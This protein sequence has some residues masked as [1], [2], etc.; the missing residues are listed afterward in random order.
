MDREDL[1]RLGIDPAAAAVVGGYLAVLESRLPAGRRSRAR[2]LAEISDGLACALGEQTAGG[3]PP[4]DAARRAVAEFGDP[5]MLAAAFARQLGPAAAHRAG[6]GLV[7][8]GPLVGGT[9]VAAY[10]SGGMGLPEQ[11]A[12]LLSALPQLAL[13]LAVTVP[14]ALIA[15]CGA[16][17]PSRYVRVPARVVTGAALVASIGCAAGDLSLLLA[18]V[19]GHRLAAA[20]PVSLFAAAALISVARLGAA[21][22]TCRRMAR[23]RA[24][25]Y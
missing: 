21:G 22:W 9:W 10:G 25:A 20:G 3:A 4:A 1:T 13:I 17:W 18:T 19:L 12:G 23:L 2:I 7:A 6:L 8:T 15:I 14:A 5:R 24:A 16:G 11:V